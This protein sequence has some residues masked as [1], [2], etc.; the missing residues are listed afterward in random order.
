MEFRFPYEDLE[1]WK[2][3]KLFAVEVYKFSSRFPDE[4]K[5]GL[6][7]QVRRA[8]VSICSNIA[9]GSAKFS[10]KEQAYYIQTAY[11]SL[12]EA[13]CQLDLAQELGFIV[14]EELS[15]IRVEENIYPE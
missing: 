2:R 7:S 8:A 14:F 4:E 3:A 10:K 11:G 5:Y 13:M 15:A 6:T 12:L 9:E 1:I